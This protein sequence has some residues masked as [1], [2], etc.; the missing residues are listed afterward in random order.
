VV[1]ISLLWGAVNALACLLNVIEG[2]LVF[3]QSVLSTKRGGLARM[4]FFVLSV[5]QVC[6]LAGSP[7]LICITYANRS[8]LKG[9]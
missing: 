6:C 8:K 4:M 3:K 9:G 1:G 7:H 5:A 2:S